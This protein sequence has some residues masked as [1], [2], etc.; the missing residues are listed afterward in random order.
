MNLKIFQLFPAAMYAHDTH[1]TLTSMNAEELVIRLENFCSFS[2]ISDQ[3]NSMALDCN[4]DV[5]VYIVCILY[6]IST[7]YF[8]HTF[9]PLG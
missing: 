3:L 5:D 8:L 9:R 7:L 4:V 6:Y 2:H 1:V